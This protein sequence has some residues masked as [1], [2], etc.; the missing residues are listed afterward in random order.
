MNRSEKVTALLPT[1]RPEGDGA[2][3]VES[4][5]LDGWRYLVTPKSP[6]AP[7]SCQCDDYKHRAPKS[8]TAYRC[9]H[10]LAV[11]AYFKAQQEAKPK[12][13]TQN[14]N[15][16]EKHIAAKMAAQASAPKTTAE[17]RYTEARDLIEQGDGN[18][19]TEAQAFASWLE[20]VD[21]AIDALPHSH[22]ESGGLAFW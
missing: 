5:S 22:Q 11:R 15:D 2:Y 10:I 13:I 17:E 4:L 1:V 3:S 19:W 20:M 6:T 9:I 14:Q 21:E 8:A 18:E 7:A 12:T 16:L